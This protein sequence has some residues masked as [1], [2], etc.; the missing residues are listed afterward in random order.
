MYGDIGFDTTGPEVHADGEIWNGV[1][2]HVRRSSSTPT[3]P[4]ASRRVTA[5]LQL[6]C[7]FGTDYKLKGLRTPARRLPR[8]PSWIQYIYDAWLL[9]ANGRV[10]RRHEEHY[11]RGGQGPDGWCRPGGHGDGLR[12]RRFRARPSSPGDADTLSL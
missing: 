12:Q 2:M 3:T 9:Q 1:Q 7:A 5:K 11:A 4:R 8:K 6:S 10:L